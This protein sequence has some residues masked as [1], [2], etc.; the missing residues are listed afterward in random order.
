MPL[1]LGHEISGR[2]AATG[3]GMTAWPPGRAAV[4]FALESCGTCRACLAGRRTNA[5]SARPG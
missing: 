2:V 4:E 5:G 1:T 3:P